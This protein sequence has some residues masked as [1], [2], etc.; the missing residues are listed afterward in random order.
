MFKKILFVFC[1]SCFYNS[2][3]Q[4]FWMKDSA[5]K[6]L[7]F[8]VEQ[9]NLAIQYTTDTTKFPRRANTNDSIPVTVNAGDWTSGF[10]PGNL[11]FLFEY[12]GDKNFRKKATQWTNSMYAQR[13][14][15]GD[16]DVGFKINSSYGNAYRLTKRNT[17][18]SIITDGAKSLRKLYNDTVGCTKSWTWFK[19]Y[20]VIIDNMM[21]L[22][23]FIKAYHFT[24]DTFFYYMANRHATT[25][26][27][28]HIRPDSTTYHVV[29][30]DK[31]TGNVVWQGTRQGFADTS[32]W[33]RGQA[34]GIYGYTMMYR[35][36]GK[37]SYLNTAKELLG[38]Y[39]EQL[40]A[41][42]IPA[43]DFILPHPY[44]DTVDA[45]AAS[46]VASALI[47]L[48]ELTLDT[49]F[50]YQGELMLASLASENYT[51]QLGKNAF[52]IIK[53]TTGGA[54]NYYYNQPHNYADY[55]YLEAL[56]RY[57]KLTN[58]TFNNRPP[59]LTNYNL[60]EGMVNQTY[61][62]TLIAF[63]LDN[64]AVTFN[65]LTIPADFNVN[66]D[67][68]ITGT[69]TSSGSFPLTIELND[70]KVLDTVYLNLK[71]NLN[72]KTQHLQSNA[73]ELIY[74]L[75]FCNDIYFKEIIAEIKI[76]NIYGIPQYYYNTNHIN[77]RNFNP[78]IYFFEFKSKNKNQV[79][80]GLKYCH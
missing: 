9:Y 24:S 48:Y 73:E 44:L 30:Y 55:Y 4:S 59:S 46:I 79:I 6:A 63:D 56:L 53:H 32:C 52:F 67:G 18:P 34:W 47:E 23:I 2:F 43:Y 22:E 3:G 42:L 58:Y 61:T 60:K 45:S 72:V 57:I 16:H 26:Q 71:I 31:N 77:T 40:P 33:S 13:L 76:Y 54:K 28:N 10:F 37:T 74:P 68:I 64:D 69:P 21:N 5:L 78:G 12:T 75:P 29:D 15:S 65:P 7:D 66:N 62:D 41:D 14:N 19:P 38:Y 25:T 50:L 49:F 39:L 80:K 1:F 70:G 8:A 11:W 36:T 17:Y 51:A 35:E 27:V 20:P